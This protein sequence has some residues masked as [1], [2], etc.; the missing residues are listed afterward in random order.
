MGAL[1]LVGDQP[2]IRLRAA[3]HDADLVERE[4]A[5]AG[6]TKDAARDLPRLAQLAR[7]RNDLERAVGRRINARRRLKTLRRARWRSVAAAAGRG[8]AA[9]SKPWFWNHV[10]VGS[11]YEN[12]GVSSHGIQASVSV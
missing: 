2:L 11:A 6:E 9:R 7:C 12:T 8:S 5:L 4:T 10:R 1:E 3:Q